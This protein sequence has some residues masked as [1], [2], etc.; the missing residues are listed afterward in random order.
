MEYRTDLL[1][2]PRVQPAVDELRQIITDRYPDATFEV[3][4]GEDPEGVYLRA[5]VDVEDAEE[6][7]DAVVDRLLAM[8]IDDELPV[9]VVP[10]RPVDRVLDSMRTEQ[11]PLRRSHRLME[12]GA[13]LPI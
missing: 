12:A 2:D 13:T 6:V 11:K 7:F 10:I 4:H 9:Y 1:V 5:T 3:A 8:Q